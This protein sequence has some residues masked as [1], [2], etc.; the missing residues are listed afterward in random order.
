MRLIFASA[1]LLSAAPVWAQDSI[2]MN[3]VVIIPTVKYDV[4]ADEII[5]Q[6]T[7]QRVNYSSSRQELRPGAILLVP[8]EALNT[9]PG[10]EI[11]EGSGVE[12][13]TSIR[14][15]VLTGGAGAGSF[16]YMLDGI[17]LRAPGFGNVNGF[18][19]MPFDLADSLTV[20]K[21]P[22]TAA[23]GGNAQHGA[24][25]ASSF[26]NL[27]NRASLTFGS[28]DYVAG[29]AQFGNETINLGVSAVHDGGFRAE[30]GYDVQKLLFT[31]EQDCESWT[32]R[33]VFTATNLNQET[34][35]FAQGVD[36]Y[37]DDEIAF[38][39]ANPEAFRDTQSWLGYVAAFREIGEDSL[40]LYAYARSA[41]MDFRLHFL[42]GQALERNDHNSVGIEGRYDWIRGKL[43]YGVNARAEYTKGHLDEV[44]DASTRFSFIQGDHYDYDVDARRVEIGADVTYRFSRKLKLSGEARLSDVRYDYDNNIDSGIFGRFLRLDDRS[45]NFTLFSPQISATYVFNERLKSFAKLAHSE[46][47]PQTTDLYRVQINQADN[48]ADVETL[49]AI[50]AGLRG[51]FGEYD[52][53]TWEITAYIQRKQNFFFRDA[54]GFN[55]AD[56]ITDH[57]GIE[58]SGR[59]RINDDW[60]IS[61][62]AAFA[63]NTYGFTNQVANSSEIITDGNDIDTAPRVTAYGLVSYAPSD[64]PY[65]VSLSVNHIGEYFTNA[66][67]SRDYPGHTIVTG[68]ATYELPHD[69]KLLLRAE[70]IFDTRY[71]NRADFAFGNERYFPGRPR[72][73]FVTVEKEF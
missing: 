52:D 35:G 31:A 26:F 9:I 57:A 14:S 32:L 21:G 70:N 5:V 3:D 66:A 2:N 68:G 17:S 40:S 44:Q 39:N 53:S 38:G 11:Q 25:D 45:D 12:S 62:N 41:D 47:A 37:K 30:S 63:E 18:L 49:D 29:K 71:A 51:T 50:E 59:Y 36:A 7:V 48:P 23:Y 28:D 58:L 22:H 15:P 27:E 20:L 61:G 56:G 34:A 60:Q 73:L 46:R 54:D 42:P 43:N 69:I 6:S 16:A 1:L 33:G 13:L 24:I 10:V 65:G 4:E 72:S 67:N 19:E 64:K 55:V 8:S